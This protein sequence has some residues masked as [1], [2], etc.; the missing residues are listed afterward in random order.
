M[1]LSP[2]ALAPYLGDDLDLAVVNGPGLTVASGADAALDRLAERLQAEDIHCQRI[3]INIAAHSRLLDPV[4]D[5]F[6]DYL[7]SIDLHAPQIPVISNR[8]GQILTDAEATSPDYW[9]SHLRG[10]V[11]FADGLATLAE[12]PSRV[13]LEVGPGK[14]LT[15]L[16][17]QHPK[18][19]ANQVINSLRHP[20]DE[21]AQPCSSTLWPAAATNRADSRNQGSPRV[22]P[23]A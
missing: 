21:T 1:A 20:D 16:A 12:N 4:L 7:R 9:V 23:A 15:S 3:A 10:A 2:E 17:G 14:A 11:R 22:R 18:I 13:Y 19:D 5:R 6:G 8:S